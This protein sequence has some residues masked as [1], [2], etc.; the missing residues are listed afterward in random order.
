MGHKKE[1]RT[2]LIQRTQAERQK[3]EDLRRKSACALKIQSF[4][5]G[6]WVRHQQYKLQRISFDKAVSSIQGSK[7]IPAASDVRILLRKLLFFYSD[8]KDAQRLV[9]ESALHLI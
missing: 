3:R 7:D 8:S 1:E 2:S 5:R 4:L 9:R 6:A